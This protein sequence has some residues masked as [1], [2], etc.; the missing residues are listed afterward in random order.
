[1]TTW[2]PVVGFEGLYEASS[3]GDIRNTKTNSI[4]SKNLMGAGYVKA[5]LWKDGKR[6]QT[7]AHR[8]IAEA[9]IG[10]LDGAE[11][12]HKNGIKTDNRVVTLEITSRSENVL[13]SMYELGKRIKAVIRVDQDSSEKLYPS[14]TSVLGDGFNRRHVLECALGKRKT[15][16]GFTWKLSAAPKGEQP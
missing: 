15:H 8:I 4:L 2:L 11:V 3:E 5:A 1:M 16:K 12:N 13:H 9:F 6:T 10:P 14:I 7:S